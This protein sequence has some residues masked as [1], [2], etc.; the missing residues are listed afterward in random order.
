VAYGSGTNEPALPTGVIKTVDGGATWTAQD[1]GIHAMLLV[2]VFLRDERRG[3][4][5]GGKAPRPARSRPRRR[6]L[7]G[8][9]PLDGGATWENRLAGIA[10]ELRK[11]E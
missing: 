6:R 4:V 3:W 8:A 9:R 5:V 7:G 10:G 2:D 11:G 1:M